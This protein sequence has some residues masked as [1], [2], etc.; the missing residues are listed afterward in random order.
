MFENRVIAALLLAVA[1]WTDLAGAQSVGHSAIEAQR[2]RLDSLLPE[3]H[4]VSQALHYGDSLRA[5]AR[6]RRQVEL[7]TA[8]VGPFVVIT[9]D[10]ESREHFRNFSRAVNERAVFLDGLHAAAMELWVERDV[11]RDDALRHHAREA[12]ARHVR[13]FGGS[14]RLRLRFTKAAVDD[15]VFGFLPGNVQTWLGDSDLS[16][17]RAHSLVYRELATSQFRLVRDCY[18]GVPAACAQALQFTDR[19]RGSLSSTARASLL[20]HALEKG[21]AGSLARLR[22]AGDLQLADAVAA[23]AGQPLDQLMKSWHSSITQGYVSHAGLP[24]AAAAALIWGA[25]A[26][27]ISL[28]STRRRAE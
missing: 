21:G 26:L 24:R 17:G 11:P 6:R 23:A 3:L 25:I 16:R 18:R 27:L 22:A 8:V 20:L 14:P 2:A 13:I 10:K 28:R 19:E 4:A 5:E 7:D 1:C 9:H 15:A 12:N